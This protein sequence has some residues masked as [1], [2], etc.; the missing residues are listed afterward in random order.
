LFERVAEKEGKIRIK[1]NR[2]I[3]SRERSGAAKGL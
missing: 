3:R 2:E 1:P